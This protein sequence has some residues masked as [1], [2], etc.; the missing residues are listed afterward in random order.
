MSDSPPPVDEKKINNVESDDL[1]FSTVGESNFAPSIDTDVCLATIQIIFC[2]F[3]DYF[4]L[5]S[6][7]NKRIWTK[8]LT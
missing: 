2:R 4:F 3:N 6:R 5:N 7:V 8:Y 1:F